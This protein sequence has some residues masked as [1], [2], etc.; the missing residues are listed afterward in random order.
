MVRL[1]TPLCKGTSAPVAKDSPHYAVVCV[2]PWI[3]PRFTLQ[4]VLVLNNAVCGHPIITDLRAPGSPSLYPLLYVGSDVG[5][6]LM[7]SVHSALS[8]LTHSA[9]RS[10][11]GYW[12]HLFQILYSNTAEK[13]MPLLR[14]EHILQLHGQTAGCLPGREGSENVHA[15]NTLCPRPVYQIQG[16]ERHRWQRRLMC[17]PAAKAG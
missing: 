5:M 7:E 8:G 3:L 14:L 10:L 17:T 12:S 11:A 9:V 15:G 4:W 6:S 16:T 2:L 1:P 13:F